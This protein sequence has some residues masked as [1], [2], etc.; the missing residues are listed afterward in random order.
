MEARV[1]ASVL[2]GPRGLLN[3]LYKGYQVSFPGVKQP[4]RGVNH[5]LRSSAEVPFLGLH[6]LF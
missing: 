5:P 3:L 4:G 2:T 1:S 6:G